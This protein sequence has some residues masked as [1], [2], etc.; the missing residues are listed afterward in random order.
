[1]AL[2]LS[3][4]PSIRDQIKL[5]PSSVY[6]LSTFFS[7]CSIFFLLVC[8]S[9][10]AFLVSPIA[11]AFLSVPWPSRVDEV[12][13]SSSIRSHRSWRVQRLCICVSV[14]VDAIRER[15]LLDDSQTPKSNRQIG[16]DRLYGNSR[17]W[18]SDR[19]G[20]EVIFQD[21]LSV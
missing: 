5:P 11:S 14:C 7:F 9:S 21:I 20:N 13:T 12:I 15:K 6:L 3:I 18:K 10:I 19:K 17:N 2:H 16:N 8:F 1:M 4:S